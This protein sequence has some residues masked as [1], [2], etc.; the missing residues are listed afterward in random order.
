MS[1]DA[2][3]TSIGNWWRFELGEIILFEHKQIEKNKTP[4][5]T[6]SQATPTQHTKGLS[7]NTSH[8]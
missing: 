6:T 8:V 4:I 7:S 1:Y 3:A 5:D 2:E